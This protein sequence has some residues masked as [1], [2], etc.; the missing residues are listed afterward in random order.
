MKGEPT[1]QTELTKPKGFIGSLNC[2]I[3]GILWAAK[4]Q[5]HML[6]HLLAA[7]LALV[8]ALVLRLTL[9]EFA[10]LALA[11]TL[12]LFAELVNTAIEV[13]ID[14]VS[15]D[16]HPLAQ[17]AKDVAAGAVLL[18]SVGAMVLGYLALSRFFFVAEVD[19]TH[20][21]MRTT[22]NLAIISVVIVVLLVILAKARVGRGT[23]LHGGM[24][25]GH[26]GVAFSIA[27]SVA[28]AEVGLLVVLLAWFL[29][30]LVAQS[31]VLLGIH[32]FKEIFVGGSLGVLTTLG[33]QLTF[34]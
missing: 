29:A 34:H 31:R 30:A 6:F 18:A 4:T 22:G 1:R 19:V 7:I 8:G 32:T 15:P 21:F 17:R 33:M 2:A 10:L 27:T 24:P 9:Q 14:L 11:I 23:P 3:E 13:T 26:A 20:D 28:F 25:S 5:R 12:V 16:F